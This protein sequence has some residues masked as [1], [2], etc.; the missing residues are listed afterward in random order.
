MPTLNKKLPNR[1]RPDS[2]RVMVAEDERNELQKAANAA[3]MALS[4]FVRVA[5]LEAARRRGQK[6]A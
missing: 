3:G 1:E 5:A 4:V 6:A 2:V